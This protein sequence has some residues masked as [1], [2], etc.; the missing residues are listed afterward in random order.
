MGRAVQRGH[1]RERASGGRRYCL[2]SFSVDVE[3]FA[4]AVRGHWP[5]ENSL[6][7]VQDVPFGATGL[8]VR[9]HTHF[10]DFTYL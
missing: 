3:K 2:S 7:G 8:Q 5:I 4:R 10:G 6:H 1:G 9:R